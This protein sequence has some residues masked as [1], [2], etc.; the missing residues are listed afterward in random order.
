MSAKWFAEQLK[1]LR[2]VKGW[3]QA[4]LAKRSGVPQATISELETGQ[5]KKGPLL[6]VAIAL[7]DALGVGLDEFREPEKKAEKK[8]RGK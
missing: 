8:R 2:T 3:S 5:A 7:A 1:L 4:E 6:D